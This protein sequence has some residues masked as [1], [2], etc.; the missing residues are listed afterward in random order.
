MN[1]PFSLLVSLPNGCKVKVTQIGGVMFG[2]KISLER[3][4]YV[5]S[6][7]YNL[8]FIHN[9][10][11]HSN[12][13]VSF[14]KMSCLMQ[15]PSMKRPWVIVRMM[16]GLYFLCP[17]CLKSNITPTNTLFPTFA[18]I[19]PT[20]NACNNCG[21]SQT[22]HSVRKTCATQS[23]ISFVPYHVFILVNVTILKVLICLLKTI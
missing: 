14:T 13:M 18:S 6:F 8:I 21:I 15:G 5:F 2:P 19:L 9:L 12:C 16:E 10:A 17:R 20:C 3:V 11:L 7:K 1:L 4:H 23:S 22:M